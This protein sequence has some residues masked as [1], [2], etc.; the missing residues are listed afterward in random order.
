MRMKTPFCLLLAVSGLLAGCGEKAGAP[1]PPAN[2]ATPGS[3]PLSAPADYLGA[4]DKAHKTADKVVD[5]AVL[6]Q[7]IQLFNVEHGRNPRDL[8]ELVEEKFIPKLPT[9]PYG[10]KLDYDAATGKV[11]VVKQ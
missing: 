8:N 5:T 10:M 7:A 4:L 2:S 3:S 6:N 11:R 1:A 9:A